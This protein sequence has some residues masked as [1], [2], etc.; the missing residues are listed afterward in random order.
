MLFSL[1]SSPDQAI[2]ALEFIEADRG[3]KGKAKITKNEANV[4]V[5]EL[6]RETPTW[7]WTLPWRIPI[8]TP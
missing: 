1:P 3:K 4:R 2:D 8:S 7:D 6:L 5:R